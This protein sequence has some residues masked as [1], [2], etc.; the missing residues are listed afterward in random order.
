MN[1]VRVIQ[2]PFAQFYPGVG[3]KPATIFS[4]ADSEIGA[5]NTLPAQQVTQH[6][7]LLKTVGAI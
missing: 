5:R 1:I 3:L 7:R 2:G 6:E 4:H